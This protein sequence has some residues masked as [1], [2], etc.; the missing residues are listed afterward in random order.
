MK[1]P[2]CGNVVA[3]LGYSGQKLVILHANKKEMGMKEGFTGLYRQILRETPHDSMH[4]I[5]LD[6]T[7]PL[8]ARCVEAFFGGKSHME[9]QYPEIAGLYRRT[10][11]AIH[12]DADDD[13]FS[14][15]VYLYDVGYDSENKNAYSM[16]NANLR[17]VAARMYSTLDIYREGQEE[18]VAHN[19]SFEFNKKW[20]DIS[21]ES[22]SY[23]IPQGTYD[24]YRA[25]M[26]TV[27]E[28]MQT[29][30]MNALLNDT[31]ATTELHGSSTEVVKN[32]TVTH[33]RHV[34]SAEDRDIVVSY[35]RESA[36]ID[37]SY[38]E[39]R[40]ESGNEKVFLDMQGE[41]ELAD[42][43]L[44]KC[45][46][47]PVGA[48]LQC[49]GYGDIFYR[50]VPGDQELRCA[51][52]KKSFSWQLNK[53][54]DNEIRDSVR[55]GNRVHFFDF[56]LRY[57][58]TETST[59]DEEEHVIIVSSK[60]YP[61]LVGKKHYRRISRI[62]L[63]WGCLA[64]DVKIVTADRQEKCISTIKVGDRICTRDGVA[65]V[66]DVVC[67][68]EEKL[69]RIKSENGDEIRASYH[70][71]FLADNGFCEVSEFNSRTVLRMA[72]GTLRKILYC[73]PEKYGKRVYSL[74]LDTGDTFL[75]SGFV[76][77]TNVLQG[78]L[79][80]NRLTDEFQQI[81]PEAAYKLRQE[82]EQLKG[83]FAAGLV[84]R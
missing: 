13:G 72:D 58:C 33:P 82:C 76:S 32:L 3:F 74:D 10:L 23:K 60:V 37:Y 38:P 14:D 47:I 54:W 61:F 59:G 39:T 22:S 29:G 63:M 12:A 25:V 48:V 44:F 64:E 1:D 56:Q 49:D 77:G 46:E 35:A 4:P 68:T 67:G 28:D 84:G 55:F 8:H 66:T 78:R 41:V 71:P 24:S 20:Q 9:K 70:H 83:D 79:A 50:H 81:P 52:D 73:Y 26:C 6:F 19:A 5:A 40:A 15:G 11:H 34:V 36:G 31:N 16:G 75:C 17:H 57:R 21:A 2:L 62:Q 53:D 51:E 45:F 42:G 43:Y 69:Y 7:K 18:P 27:W 80:D 65:T 30:R